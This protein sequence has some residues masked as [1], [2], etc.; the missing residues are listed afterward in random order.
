MNSKQNIL[1]VD[2]EKSN[3]DIV[4]NLFSLVDTQ[5]YTKPN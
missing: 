2:D 5:S 4:V 1:I 3:I